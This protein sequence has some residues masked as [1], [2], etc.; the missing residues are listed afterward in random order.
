MDALTTAAF[1]LTCSA[2]AQ[3]AEPAAKLAVNGEIAP[4]STP[5]YKFITP[6]ERFHHFV[7]KTIGPMGVA[8]MAALSG[9][10]T[11]RQSPEEWSQDFRGY[12]TRLG[13]RFGRLA[14][15][16]TIELG[17]SAALRE[18]P[19]YFISRENGFGARVKNALLSTILIR[20]P[21]GSKSLAI[22]RLSGR[23]GSSFIQN[24]WYPPSQNRWNDA[25]ERV[26]VSFGVHA[27]FNLAKEFWRRDKRRK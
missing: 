11:M 8:Q 25:F 9:I 15:G 22:G 20:K 27:G 1:L 4:A 18:D 2:G 17:L 24:S 3:E 10:Q 26:G 23:I 6:S 7:S 13:S 5:A 19:R 16:N 14:I 12:S 21:D